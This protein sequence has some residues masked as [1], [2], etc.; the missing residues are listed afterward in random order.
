MGC[1]EA[2]QRGSPHTDEIRA[3]LHVLPYRGGGQL[4]DIRPSDIDDWVARLA[5]QMGPWAV[6]H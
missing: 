5:Q 1:G 6:R 4:C 3:R 2:G